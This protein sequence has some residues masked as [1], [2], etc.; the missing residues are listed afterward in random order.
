MRIIVCFLSFFCALSVYAG[1]HTLQRGETFADVAKLYNIPLDSLIKANPNTDVYVGLTIEVPLSTLV[2]DLGDSDLFRNMRYCQTANYKK[3]IKMYKNAHEKQLKLNKLS[4]KTR[5]KF[6][7]QIISDYT[8]AVMYGNTD[9]LYQLGRQKVHGILYCSDGYPNFSQAV[10]TNIDEFSKG[11]EYLQIA[12]LIGHNNKALVELALACGYEGSPIRNPYLCL[13]M[14]EQYQKELGLDVNALICYMYEKGYGIYPNLLQA[15]IYCPSAELVSKGGTKTHRE[16]ILE[17]IEVM[18]TNFDSSRYGVGMDSK[19]MMSVGFSYYH[20]DILEPEGIFWLHRA[21][22]QNNAEANWALA[23]IL[24]NG[25]HAECAVGNTLNKESQILCFVKNAAVNG[26]QEAKEYLEVYEKQQKAKAEQ[27]RLRELERQRQEEE[28]K[29]RRIQMWANIAGSVIQ[30]AAQTYVAVETAKMQSYQMQGASPNFMQSMPIEQMSDAQWQARNQLA[31]QQI[32]QYTMNK[33]YADWTGTPMMPTDM[34]AVDLGTDMS[35]GSPLW[36]WG[37]QQQI[38]TMA[39]QNARMSCEISAFYKR[40]ADQI[41]QQLMENPLQPIAGF[42]DRDGNW[43]SSEMVA[44]G[45]NNSDNTDTS[46]SGERNSAFE[47]IRSKN[48]SYFAE[49]YGY[50]DC[51]LCHGNGICISCQGKGYNYNFGSKGAHTCPN[52]LMVNGQATGECIQCQGTGKVYG[53]KR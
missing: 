7:N 33:T 10:N 37:M 21:A 1:P 34:S 39:T 30:A 35:P 4:G 3:G 8:E 16:K 20:D 44:A 23:S 53:L 41:T 22:R 19:T 51:F 25:N 6:E 49:R 14:L 29:Q 46:Y 12:A 36:N 27:A 38:N 28:R 48:R 43:I 47:E 15:Y 50:K 9:A 17:Q 11:I 18:P 40:Q 42:V 52:C 5:Q 24:H 31:L 45:Y 13:G 32:A 2:Y 26:K